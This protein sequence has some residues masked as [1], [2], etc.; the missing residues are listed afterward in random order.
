MSKLL[1]VTV[2]VIATALMMPQAALAGGDRHRDDHGDRS[3]FK[4][5]AKKLDLS[6]E[7][8]EQIKALMKT[9]REEVKPLREKRKELVAKAR[10]IALSEDIDRDA[11]EKVSEQAAIVHAQMSELRWVMYHEIRALLTQE[12]QTKFDSMKHG[13]RGRRS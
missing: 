1:K 3:E 5:Y 8:R 6:S 13:V 9:A 12:Q 11:L 2:L 10:K 4:H 7:Q